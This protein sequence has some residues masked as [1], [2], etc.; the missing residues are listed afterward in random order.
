[1]ANV[2][3]TELDFAFTPLW[4]TELIEIVQGGVNKKLKL[5]K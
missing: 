2:K 4:G 5:M 3:I 1:M